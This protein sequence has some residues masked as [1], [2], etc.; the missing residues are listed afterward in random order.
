MDHFKTLVF[1]IVT[2]EKYVNVD[3]KDGVIRLKIKHIAFVDVCLY[4]YACVDVC[5]DF[6]IT[7]HL[8]LSLVS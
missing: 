5:P 4:E 7:T 8:L 3:C 1:P 2:L 6:N